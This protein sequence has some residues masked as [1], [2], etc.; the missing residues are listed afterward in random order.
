MFITSFI[1]DGKF[2]LTNEQEVVHRPDKKG[3]GSEEIVSNFKST[4]NKTVWNTQTTVCFERSV[5]DNIQ[6]YNLKMDRSK[7]DDSLDIYI[8]GS[9]LSIQ[10]PR[11]KLVSDS[12]QI[13]WCHNL[14]HNIV[15][16]GSLIVDTAV[17]QEIDTKVLDLNVQFFRSNMSGI[18]HMI[19]ERIGNTPKLQDWSNTL[20]D[21]NIICELPWFYKNS[22]LNIDS[23]SIKHTFKFRLS[24]SELI[25]VRKNGKHIKFDRA[26]FTEDTPK[27][28]DIPS[29][30]GLCSMVDAELNHEPGD[31]WYDDFIIKPCDS[32]MTMGNISRDIS[33]SCKHE[34]KGM[35]VMCENLASMEE[36]NVRSDYSMGYNC[37]ISFTDESDRG[38][39]DISASH[40]SKIYADKFGSIPYESGYIP[41][42]LTTTPTSRDIDP[43]VIFNDGCKLTVKPR[44]IGISER[45]QFYVVLYIMRKL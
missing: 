8:V 4:F 41:I 40:F 43:G 3:D 42:A 44:P 33:L 20:N 5:S 29:I 24:I 9:Y 23:H 22:H 17:K 35:F 36:Y 37:K 26:L 1:K 15:E 38:F 16:H 28:I 32:Y 11:I 18:K 45:L 14:V 39:K 7:N 13:K 10:L 19:R 30:Y 31:I 2:K 12:Y 27:V 6:V 25:E 34:V 21:E